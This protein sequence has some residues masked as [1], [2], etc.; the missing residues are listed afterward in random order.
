MGTDSILNRPF[1]LQIPPVKSFLES[2]SNRLS[3]AYGKGS[4]EVESMTKPVRW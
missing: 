3:D 1:S 4:E 2:E